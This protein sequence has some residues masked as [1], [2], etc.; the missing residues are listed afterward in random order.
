MIL[1]QDYNCVP[2]GM[3]FITVP[4]WN[5]FYF[6]Q[7]MCQTSLRG[8]RVSRRPPVYVYVLE[9]K[10]EYRGG[11]FLASGRVFIYYNEANAD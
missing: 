4:K 2:C 3:I 1:S 5:L 6:S 9:L 7:F 11:V 10:V 8:I